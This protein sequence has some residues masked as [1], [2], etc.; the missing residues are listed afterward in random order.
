MSFEHI[1]ILSIGEMGYHW[2]RTLGA[3]GVKIL[4]VLGNRSE[5]TRRRAESVQ[6]EHVPSMEELVSRVDLIVSIVVPFAAKPVAQ[7]VARALATSGRR[8]L[9]YLD[10]NAISPM[11]AEEIGRVVTRAG[12]TYV[13]GC[14]LGGAAKINQGT[15]V[16]VSGE[17]AS[18]LL[19]LNDKG[20]YVKVLGSGLTQASAFK[21]L[22][23]GLTKGLA[24]LFTELL[25]GAEK[26]GLLDEIIAD[27]DRSYPGIASKVGQ[28][29]L[30]LPLHAGRRA[31]EMVE[32]RETFLHHGINPV[33]I[34]AVQ[35]VLKGIA[36]LKKT[37]DAG[38]R[39]R[40]D[41]LEEM[42]RSFAEKGLLRNGPSAKGRS[43]RKSS[44]AKKQN[45]AGKRKAG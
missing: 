1:G 16:Y 38:G 30:S 13:D 44:K 35:K 31:E 27:Y 17:Q 14:I 36:A 33:L 9:L 3:H 4:S 2:A 8:D 26:L 28:S 7:S 24:G 34:P 21:V 23:A 22:H 41:S 15:V 19:S 5:A 10:A 43:R 39:T 29:M 45:A 32:L 20:L 37:G 40:A 12:G 11:T 6:V 25:V 18:R 42:I